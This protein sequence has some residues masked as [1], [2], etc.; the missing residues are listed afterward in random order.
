M[1]DYIN[2]F[3]CIY[4]FYFI[5]EKKSCGNLLVEFLNNCNGEIKTHPVEININFHTQEMYEIYLKKSIEI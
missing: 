1:F 3:Q 2:E 4:I 5:D